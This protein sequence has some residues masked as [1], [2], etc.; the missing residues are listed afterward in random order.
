MKQAINDILMWL[1]GT[2]AIT[3]IASLLLIGWMP[4]LIKI[5]MGVLS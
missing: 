1:Y 4:E 5:S 3:F 2:I